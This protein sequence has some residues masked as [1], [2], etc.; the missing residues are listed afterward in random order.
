MINFNYSHCSSPPNS[1][2]LTCSNSTRFVFF[3]PMANMEGLRSYL[4]TMD[5]S[6]CFQSSDVNTVWSTL[7]LL[8][9]NAMELFI[10]KVRLKT[11]QYPKWFTSD[12]YHSINCLRTLRRKCKYHPS[13]ANLNN[14]KLRETQ[15]EDKISSAKPMYEN[16]LIYQFSSSNNSRIYKYI[17][18]IT[19]N[20]SIPFTVDLD[21]VH[22]TADPDKAS[23]FNTHF[24]SIFTHSSFELPSLESLSTPAST[25]CD[26]TISSFH[27]YHL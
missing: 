20:S 23:L 19:G 2:Q 15:L 14:L 4:E 13:P 21:S 6:V 10:P 8:I 25:I 18:S 24:H 7:K 1:Q 16:D 17:R 3:F 22:A 5:F 12:I 27:L 26:F 11:H 9:L